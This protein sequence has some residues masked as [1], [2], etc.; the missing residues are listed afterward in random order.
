MLHLFH[1]P[2]TMAVLPSSSFGMARHFTS[3][4]AGGRFFC[5]L[6]DK[7]PVGGLDA[8]A[9]C[10][11]ACHAECPHD[12]ITRSDRFPPCDPDF[13]HSARQTRLAFVMTRDIGAKVP[14]FGD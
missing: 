8:R 13:L 5:E 10:S 2:K 9:D 6:V 4:L 3:K 1:T 11:Q 12:A 14:D 7:L